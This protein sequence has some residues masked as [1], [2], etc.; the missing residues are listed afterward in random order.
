[1]ITEW[2]LDVAAQLLTFVLGLVPNVSPPAWLV[3]GSSAIGDLFADLGMLAHWFPV[4]LLGP[5]VLIIVLSMTAGVGVKI[6]RAVLSV[7]TGGGG[8]S[9]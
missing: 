6:G 2:L 1:M 7:F 8:S 3:S 9:G 5:A 4:W